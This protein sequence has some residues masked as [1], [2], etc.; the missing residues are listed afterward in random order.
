[1]LNEIRHIL[2]CLFTYLKILNLL[3]IQ[4][5]GVPFSLLSDAW[6]YVFKQE[7]RNNHP[8]YRPFSLA[9]NDYKDRQSLDKQQ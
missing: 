8:F 4:C 9:G 1:M 5:F 7:I 3:C 2:Y 6:T